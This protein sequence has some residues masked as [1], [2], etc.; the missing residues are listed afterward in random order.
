MERGLGCFDRW[1]KSDA[2]FP[3]K[4]QVRSTENGAS[5]FIAPIL[6]SQALLPSSV[7]HVDND[8]HVI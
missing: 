1:I 6:K 2:E 3:K 5:I 4:R 7:S 8:N